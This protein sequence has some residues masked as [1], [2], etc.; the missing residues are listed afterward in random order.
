MT[1]TELAQFSQRGCGV[2]IIGD[3]QKPSGCDPYL[4]GRIG[5]GDLHVSLLASASLWFV[6]Q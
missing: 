4:A 3:S 6:V 1:V 2:S 5:S